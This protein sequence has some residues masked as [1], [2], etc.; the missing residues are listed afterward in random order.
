MADL[1]G[2]FRD[3]QVV[4]LRL[5][6]VASVAVGGSAGTIF[7]VRNVRILEAGWL[8]CEVNLPQ[9]ITRYVFPPNQVLATKQDQLSQQLP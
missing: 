7:N 3:D 5:T 6:D 9:G 4:L 8:Q 2:V 1:T